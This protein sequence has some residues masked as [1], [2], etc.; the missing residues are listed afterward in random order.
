VA[1]VDSHL[2]EDPRPSAKARRIREGLL[3]GITQP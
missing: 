2:S 3:R 1:R